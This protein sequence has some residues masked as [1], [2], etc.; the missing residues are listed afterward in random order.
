MTMNEDM[1]KRVKRAL[2]STWDAIG[3]DM[4]V[5]ENGEPDKSRVIPR[6]HVAEIVCDAGHLEKYGDDAEAV[7]EFRK[8]KYRSSKWHAIIK[9]AFPFK[10]YGW[11]GGQT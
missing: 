8:I 1:A 11:W 5:G 4:L 2:N 6:S 3:C 7:A 9:Q 10:R